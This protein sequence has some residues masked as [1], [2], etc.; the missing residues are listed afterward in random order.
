MSITER[1]TA[2]RS[3]FGLSQK[4]MAARLGIAALVTMVFIQVFLGILTLLLVVPVH[5][6]AT[7]QAGGM[8][9]L[10]FALFVTHELMAERPQK[11]GQLSS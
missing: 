3:H 2:L 9:V 10:T 4:A 11:T 6:A 7:H 5:L 1:L 8:L